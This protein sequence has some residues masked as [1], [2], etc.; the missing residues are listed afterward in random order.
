MNNY[1]LPNH[2][3]EEQLAAWLEAPRDL[4]PYEAAELE[5]HWAAA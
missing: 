1:E 2:P 5:R 4:M 3:L